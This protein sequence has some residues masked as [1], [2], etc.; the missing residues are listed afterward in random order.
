MIN[1]W[2]HLKFFRLPGCVGLIQ[3]ECIY[4]VKCRSHLSTGSKCKLYVY[5]SEQSDQK[6]NN[7]KKAQ[8]RKLTITV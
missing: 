1:I 8:P 3:P 2:P 6:P 4:T 5:L 7:P